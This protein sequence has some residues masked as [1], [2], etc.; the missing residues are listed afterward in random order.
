MKGFSLIRISV[1]SVVF[2][3]ILG[4]QRTMESV[5]SLEYPNLE[6]IIIDGGSTDGTKEL[7]QSYIDSKPAHLHIDIAKFISQKDDGIYDAMNKGVNYSSGEY[8]SFM[9]AGDIFY[10][11]ASLKQV[12]NSSP[13]DADII[14]TDTQ[15]C[16]DKY[17]SKILKASHNHKFHHKFIHQS[18]LIR[19]SL[20]KK[21]KYDTSFKI[22]GDTHF[23][24]KM[25]NLG[26]KFHY[27]DMVLSSF[28]LDG[29]SSKFS[30]TTL[31]E[32]CKIAK[33]YSKVV[34]FVLIFKYFTISFPKFLLKKAMPQR[35]ANKLRVRFSKNKI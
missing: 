34:P 8:L 4:M 21:Y 15:I 14:Y 22:A 2:N 1:I 27:V 7:I 35:I 5:M 29:I 9:N 12:I 16:Y 10:S 25:Y 18:S 23:L 31:K 6:Y 33:S 26:Y 19:A 17:N 3:D 24:V 32:D 30:L 13:S 20:L 28:N 11:P